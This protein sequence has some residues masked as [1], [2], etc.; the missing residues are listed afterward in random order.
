MSACGTRLIRTA[1]GATIRIRAL[2]NFDPQRQ[3]FKPEANSM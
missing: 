2:R 1:A 3:A